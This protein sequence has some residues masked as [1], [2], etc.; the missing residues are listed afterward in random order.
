MKR[1]EKEKE[2]KRGKR[3]ENGTDKLCQYVT[4]CR[5]CVYVSVCCVC[6]FAYVCV[7]CV[8][9]VVSCVCCVLACVCV[10]CVSVCLCVCCVLCVSVCVLCVCLHLSPCLSFFLS[11]SL[12]LALSHSHSLI[13]SN[14]FR[15]RASQ[16]G[17][18][19]ILVSLSRLFTVLLEPGPVPVSVISPLSDTTPVA[20]PVTESSLVI[21]TGQL[22]AL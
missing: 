9:C 20:V 17:L 5:V 1:K 11:L 10:L 8:L 7:L 15:L 22:T 13:L 6:V 19:A 4:L 21:S 12:S 18:P 3:E 2:N 16:K 14:L